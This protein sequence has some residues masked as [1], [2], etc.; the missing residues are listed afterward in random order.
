MCDAKKAFKFDPGTK[1]ATDFKKQ[2]DV[3]QSAGRNARDGLFGKKPDMDQLN[4]DAEARAKAETEAATMAATDATNQKLR[5]RNMGMAA[6][7]LST[8]A[9]K[10]TLGA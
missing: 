3:L 7:V 10:T 8:G 6:S 1:F 5:K 4:R 2:G 9:G